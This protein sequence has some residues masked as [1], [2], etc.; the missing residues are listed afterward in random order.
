[1]TDHARRGRLYGAAGVVLLIAAVAAVGVF[2]RSQRDA[3]HPPPSAASPVRV[4]PMRSDSASSTPP[5][6]GAVARP[7]VRVLT[8]SVPVRLAI[9]AIHVSTRVQQLGLADDGSVQV[10]PLG[11]DSH[12]GWYRYSPAPGQLGPS[13]I[14]GHVDSAK[15]GQGVFFRLGDLRQRDRI[16]VTRADGT[17]AVFA[18]ERVVEYHKARF[19]TLQVYGNLDHAGLRLITCGGRFDPRQHSYEDNIVVYASLIASHHA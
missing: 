3:P 16:S 2:V 19:P 1:M 4:T 12:A 17:V 11:R 10:P 13:I 9:P 18:V 6:R 15:Y 7:D 14:L 5:P 8:R